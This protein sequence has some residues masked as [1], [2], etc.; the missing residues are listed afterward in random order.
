[1]SRTV[2]VRRTIVVEYDVEI[3]AYPGMTDD[4]IVAWE[5]SEEASEDP[6]T[7]LESIESITTDVTF[8]GPR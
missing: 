6:G 2:H 8:S 7:W 5:K 4:E 3:E 1:M